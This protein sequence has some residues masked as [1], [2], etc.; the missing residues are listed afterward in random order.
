M[1]RGRCSKCKCC[2]NSLRPDPPNLRQ[3]RYCS[4]PSC[5]AARKATPQAKRAGSPGR[6]TTTTSAD[7]CNSPAAR[8]GERVVP[9]IGVSPRTA[10]KDVSTA[11]A[12]GCIG[13]T[14]NFVCSPPQDLLTA[15]RAVLIGLIAHLVGTPQQDDIARTTDRLLRLGQDILAVRGSGRSAALTAE[16]VVIDYET[17][18]RPDPS[19]QLEDSAHI[20]L[21]NSNCWTLVPRT[22]G[23]RRQVGLREEL[24]VFGGTTRCDR[25]DRPT[26][27]VR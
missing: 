21:F 7:L 2:R 25:W 13:K 18:A 14:G 1:A 19:T 23:P 12:L 26:K 22:M 16:R 5:R 17:Y 6:R 24:G 11:Q 15:Q 20:L 27:L 9:A 8:P 4:E 10:P 3:Q